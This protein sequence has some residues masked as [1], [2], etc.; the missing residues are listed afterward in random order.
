[1]VVSPAVNQIHQPVEIKQRYLPALTGLRALAAYLVFFH[2]YNP[3]PADTIAHQVI[4]Q[5]YIGVS[6]FFTLSGFLIYYQYADRFFANDWSWRTY[7]Q[8]R[9]ARIF[10]LYY[11]LLT[12]TFAAKLILHKPLDFTTIWL[13]LTMFK[14]FFDAYKFTGIAQSW[15]TTT[16]ETFYLFAPL[17]FVGLQRVGW[18]VVWGS[19]LTIGFILAGTG[20]FGDVNFVL[21]YTFFGRCFDFI[22]GM[23]LARYIKNYGFKPVRFSTSLG[24][25]S[26]GL[27]LFLQT[28]SSLQLHNKTAIILSEFI[29]YNVLLPGAIG[30]MIF[31]LITE[32]TTFSTLLSTNLFNQLGKRSYA[33]FMVHLGVVAKVLQH[34]FVGLQVWELFISLLLLA[35]LLYVWVERPLH[36]LLRSNEKTPL[37]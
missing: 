30:M 14:G 15:S 12:A 20:A 32:K 8:N 3:A 33:F 11:L 26:I 35:H 18:P 36:R 22:V 7:L 37:S 6:V 34:L 31:G 4:A 5:G 23:L 28:Y 17:L 1:M 9:V 16:E 19:L 24:I 10:P 21:F 27:I 13:N 29:L 25:V 2:H